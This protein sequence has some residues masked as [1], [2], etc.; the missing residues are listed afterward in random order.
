METTEQQLLEMS[1]HMKELVDTKDEELRK[2]KI[3]YMN[4]KKLIGKFYGL[5]RI[6]QQEINTSDVWEA[7]D[8]PLDWAIA[9]IRSNSSD[10]LF[11][12]EEHSLDIYG[13]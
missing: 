10:Y 11:E 12:D 4:G 2:Y 8:F 9:E 7:D 1:K 6:I 5:I 13:Y 3:K